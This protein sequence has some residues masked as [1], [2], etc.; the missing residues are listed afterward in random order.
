MKKVLGKVSKKDFNRILKIKGSVIMAE[1]KGFFYKY[2][3]STLDK[4]F[5]LKKILKRYPIST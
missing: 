1:K 3:L 4:V 5:T 2:S